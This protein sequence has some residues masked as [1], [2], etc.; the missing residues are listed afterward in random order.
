MSDTTRVLSLYIPFHVNSTLKQ[1]N[2]IVYRGNMIALSE[3]DREELVSQIP[4]YWNSEKDLLTHFVISDDATY[5]CERK[6][7]YY[8]FAT[9]QSEEKVY[10]FDTA[11]PQKVLELK[12]IIFNFYETKR[13]E[14]ITNLQKHFVDRLRDF[15]FFKSYLLRL[16]QNFLQSSDYMFL[17]DYPIPDEEKQKWEQFRQELRDITLQEAW[18][19]DDYLN[20]SFP[21]SPQE[22][23]QIQYMIDMAQN[24]GLVG[25]LD[26][27]D[28]SFNA[29]FIKNYTRVLVKIRIIDA[30]SGLGIPSIKKILG[31]SLPEFNLNGVN[32]N[33]YLDS[34]ITAEN[35]SQIFSQMDM[36]NR[37]NTYTNEIESVLQKIDPN[38]NLDQVWEIAQEIL[39]TEDKMEISEDVQSLLDDLENDLE[40]GE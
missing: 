28:S 27:I 19:N 30:L 6:K 11:D 32:D 26:S 7:Q 34:P 8:N 16:R 29:D 15:N 4:I 9:K 22:K 24:A 40:K 38:M 17:S 36:V 37:I 33:E 35:V 39:K 1:K 2:Y 23:E 20:V 14:K 3:E 10:E 5:F 21:V 25:G 18:Q 12:N 13:L 31:L